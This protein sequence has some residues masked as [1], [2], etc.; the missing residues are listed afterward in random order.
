MAEVC[1]KKTGVKKKYLTPVFF[2]C[3][4]AKVYKYGENI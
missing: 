2:Y 4:I 3:M 1:K